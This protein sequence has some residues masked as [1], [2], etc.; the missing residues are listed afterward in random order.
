[1]RSL[2]LGLVWEREGTQ[3]EIEEAEE[4]WNIKVIN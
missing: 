3:Q 1:M 4:L 2:Q